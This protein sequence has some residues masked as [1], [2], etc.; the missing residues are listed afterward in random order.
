LVRT[1]DDRSQVSRA[2]ILAARQSFSDWGIWPKQRAD[3]DPVGWLNNFDA[4]DQELAEALLDAFVLFNADLTEQLFISACLSMS[5]RTRSAPSDRL[6][7]WCVFRS[8][9]IVT[10]PGREDQN[11]ADS[12]HRFAAIAR[13]RIGFAE[14]NLFAP[15]EAVRHLAALTTPRPVVIVDDF[16]GTGEQFLESWKERIVVGDSRTSSFADEVR[17]LSISQCYLVTAVATWRGIDE[18][19]EESPAVE[20]V[21]AHM[22]PPQASLHHPNTSLVPEHLIEGLD[23]FVEKYSRKAGI[24]ADTWGYGNLATTV[25]FEHGI[26]DS[27]L[28]LYWHSSA[29][30][31]PLRR[32]R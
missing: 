28:P 5:E 30:W 12:G 14:A 8:S 27:T 9:A 2:S 20:V 1:H 19:K 7:E 3:V 10:F 16:L 23:S 32:R 21:S 24:S 31:T 25:G 4:E 26:P 17:R 18:L 13:N 22:L 29:T 15:A 6:A 11:P